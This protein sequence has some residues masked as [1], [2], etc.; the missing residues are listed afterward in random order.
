MRILILYLLLE[1]FPLIRPPACIAVPYLSTFAGDVELSNPD[2]QFTDF[3]VLIRYCLYICMTLRIRFLQVFRKLRKCKF[4]VP[5][6]ES[7]DFLQTATLSLL[8]ILVITQSLHQP[9]HIYKI[10]KIYTLKH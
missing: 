7:S 3:K 8:S 4:E 10:Y 1:N 5:S 6:R 9:L 2:S